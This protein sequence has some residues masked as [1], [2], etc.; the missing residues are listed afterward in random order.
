MNAFLATGEPNIL[1]EENKNLIK[2]FVYTMEE[3]YRTI[4]L[5]NIDK[6]EIGHMI[7]GTE[8]DWA[9]NDGSSA[10]FTPVNNIVCFEDATNQFDYQAYYNNICH[11]GQKHFDTIRN[12]IFYTFFHECGHAID[13]N[14]GK[15][16]FTSLQYTT[17]SDVIG[18][19]VT[20]MDAVFYDVYT[21]IENQ[22]RQHTSDETEINNILET[23]RYGHNTTEH[24][25][26]NETTIREKVIEYYSLEVDS[27]TVNDIM[28]G[29]TNLIIGYGHAPSE[30]TSIEDFHYWYDKNGEPTGMQAKEL[31]AEYFG[32]VTGNAQYELEDIETYFLEAYKVLQSMTA[33]MYQDI[34]E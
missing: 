17:Y 14:N 28:G 15:E 2:F 21:Y 27:S 6:F 9:K 8:E 13:Y 10:Y 3:P 12:E 7:D 16:G 4:F 24:L 11:C 20:L 22:I 34:I 18:K 31:W 33:Q 25:T 26:E 29:V 23:F 5:E 32:F 1:T 30:G 19:D